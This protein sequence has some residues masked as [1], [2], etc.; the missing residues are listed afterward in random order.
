MAAFNFD[1]IAFMKPRHI[2]GMAVRVVGFI[3]AV[4][5]VCIVAVGIC[6]TVYSGYL[7]WEWLMYGVVFV[8]LG[9]LI[10]LFVHE[11][12][13]FAYSDEDSGDDA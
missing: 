8:L 11:I 12:V 2:F 5:G 10:I 9:Y 13:R 3:V 4:I 7:D 1:T 6:K